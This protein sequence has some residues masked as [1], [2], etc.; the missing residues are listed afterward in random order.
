VLINRGDAVVDV[1]DLRAFDERVVEQLVL[2]I[3]WVIDDE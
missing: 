2:G 3:E 1:L